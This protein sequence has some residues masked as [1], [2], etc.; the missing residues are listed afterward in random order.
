MYNVSYMLGMCILYV[1]YNLMYT[2]DIL[3]THSYTPYSHTIHISIRP[4][5]GYTNYAHI[6]YHTREA[7]N[8]ARN[9]LNH[10][11]VKGRA[12]RVEW[13]VSYI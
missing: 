8:L 12:L 2:Y 7:A 9:K 6:N 5:P 4:M 1:H 3:Y 13:L 11:E 10:Y